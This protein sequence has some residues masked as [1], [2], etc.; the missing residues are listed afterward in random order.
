M[1][2]SAIQNSRGVGFRPTDAIVVPR[3]RDFVIGEVAMLDIARS[4]ATTTSATEGKSGSS[5]VQIVTPTTAGAQYGF[6]CIMLENIIKG[7]EGRARFRGDVRALMGGSGVSAGDDLSAED[8]VNTLLASSLSA[9][10]IIAT[11]LEDI[12]A[13]KLGLVAFNGIEGFGVYIAE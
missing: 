9:Q 3:G 6:L 10:K 8:A 1:L 4:H 7:M 12:L 13:N 5:L 2:I 11:P